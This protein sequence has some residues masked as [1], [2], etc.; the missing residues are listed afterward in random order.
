MIL[1]SGLLRVEEQGKTVIC[2][3]TSETAVDDTVCR[4]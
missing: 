4:F 3:F 1:S 2:N